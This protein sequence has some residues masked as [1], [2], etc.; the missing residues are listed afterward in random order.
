MR[1]VTKSKL[2]KMCREGRWEV[3]CEGR[4]LTEVRVCSTGKRIMVVVK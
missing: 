4:R 3:V 2:E 1:E